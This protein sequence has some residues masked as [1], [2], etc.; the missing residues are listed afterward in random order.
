[1]LRPDRLL[2]T[3][4]A[5]PRL[6]RRV[7]TRPALMARLRESLDSR[8]TLVHAGTGYGKTT[9]LASLCADESLR[10]IWY[11]L[12]ESDRDPQQFLAYLIAACRLQ[13]PHLSEAPLAVLQEMGDVG[14]VAN[15]SDARWTQVI[16]TL[17]NALAEA[18][19][20]PALLVLDDYHFVASSAKVNALVERCVTWLPAYL[21]VI[22]ASR[23]P[24]HFP[25]LVAW[26]A[27]GEVLEIERRELV[28]VPSEIEELFH[29]AYGML[30]TPDEAQALA[31]KTEGWPIALQLVWQGMRDRNESI[32]QLLAPAHVPTSLG[33]LFDYLARD[34]LD[35]QPLDV[36]EFLRATAV[37]HELTSEAC[38]AI[39]QSNDSGEM[40]ERLHAMDLFVVALG[41]GHY[42]YHHL[43]H[44]FL[45]SQLA[46]QAVRSQQLHGRAAQFFHDR[47]NLDQ[48][49]Y[50]WLSA[51][52]FEQAA[53]DIETAGEV[54]LRDGRLDA[55][56]TWIDALLPDVVAEHPRLQTLLG[57]VC[58]L[59]SRF[60]E[61]LAWYRQAEQT[62]RTRDDAA[63]I[64]RALHGQAL[65]Y[66]D[67][68]RPAQA[69]NLLQQA[70]RIV[71]RTADRE[72]RAQLLELLAENKLNMG[73]PDEAEALRVEAQALRADA[74][75]EDTLSVRVKLRTG[76]LD[77]A[78]RIL[79]VWA[80]SE[81]DQ[82]EQGQVHPPR[83]HRETVLILSLIHSLRGQA[84]R[85]FALAQEGITLGQLLSSPFVTAVGHMRLGHAWQL[86]SPPTPPLSGEGS[87]VGSRDQAIRCYQ[88]AIALGDQLAVRRTRAEAMWGLTRAYGFLGEGDLESAQR[89]ATE[90]VEIARWA[91]DP[92]MQSLIELAL[93]ASH[94]LAGQTEDAVEMLLRVLVAFRECGDSFGRA[95]TRLWQSLAYLDLRQSEH[96][97]ACLED[98][99][100]LAETRGYD[101]LFTAPTLLGPPD[102]RRIVPLLIAARDRRIRPAYANRLLAE[103]G[104]PDIKVHAGYQLRAQTL[105]AFR[106]W[107]GPIEIE[108]H[109]WQRDK[110]RQLFQLLVA[111]RGRWL[112]RDE[113]VEIL[114]PSLNAE[115]AARDFKVAL[116]AL[117]RA[118]E[119][120]RAAD[121][122]FAFIVRE[123]TA[124]RLR[125]EAD[126]WLD[127][128]HFERECDLGLRL[129]VHQPE[130]AIAHLQAAIRQYRGDY[131]P[132][133]LYEDWT[134]EER[135]RLLALYLR[136]ADKL[137]S[138]LVERG[139][140]DACLETCQAILTRDAC[141]ENAYRLMMT[142]YAR[143][144]NR[145]QAMRAYQRCVDALCDELGVAPSP[146]TVA[147][148]EQLAL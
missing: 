142:A 30:L 139:Q 90:G 75:S 143:Q 77:D 123:G 106:V 118:I 57:D 24:F 95:A 7:L 19:H 103:I 126:L 78:Q 68:V 25:S 64:S 3:K 53:D 11:S 36:A 112:Q 1:V 74:R 44:D 65:V 28:F 51:L 70:V 72:A 6:H 100:G 83:A 15:L 66:L 17:T 115:A 93:G 125:P 108:S 5:P 41:G 98:L 129:A 132:D 60:D 20:E 9:A 97:T 16:D 140:F 26:R 73:K 85:A 119:P 34:V 22:L 82:A 35:R 29:I 76:Q 80:E 88:S 46:S 109:E 56:T 14:Q 27:K 58:R 81:R 67:T 124:Y 117:N 127:S 148:H 37:L 121:A 13:W 52:A 120:N 86:I 101:F 59:R 110:A 133:A 48:A 131:L 55:L 31:D 94:V 84:E 141:W 8:L 23:Q 10:C 21:H 113:I 147:L 39:T 99:L 102:P 79:E 50:H 69:E 105:G 38:D 138:L 71:D 96:L 49:I 92:W 4:L 87:G 146:A 32:A 135:E 43:F 145:P 54:C 114:W 111:E 62:C 128:G 134:S 47:N 122:P 89:S 116:N 45:N 137:A 136:T 104:L 33:A 2:R 91:G 61:A 144:G 18:V 12:D 130:Q 40:L 63:G 107:R 42:R